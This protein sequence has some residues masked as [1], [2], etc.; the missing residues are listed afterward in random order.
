[1]ELVKNGTR[2]EAPG[3]LDGVRVL[4]IGNELG[5]YCGKMLA[6]LGA[7]VVRVEPPGGA[8]T[9]RFGPFLD[10]DETPEHSLYFWH[11]NF[12]KRGVTVDLDSEAG[13]DELAALVRQA[14]V[15]IDSTP[16][17]VLDTA[18]LD[19]RARAGLNPRLVDLRI[20]PFGD[21]GPYAEWL[22]TD[23]VHLALGGV[24]MNC[25]YDPGLHGHYDTPPVAPQMWHAFHITG[26]LAAMAVMGALLA[27][28]SSGRGQRL[29]TNVHQAVSQSTEIDVPNWIFLRT[30]HHRLTCRH[31]MP[32][33]T[34][35]V[36]AQ[37]K[38]GRY[39]LPYSTYLRGTTDPW[40][41]TVDLLAEHGLADDLGDGERW[42]PH[43]RT[44]R[45]G[46]QR[47]A[48]QVRRLLN[49]TLSSDE[50]WKEAQARALAWAPVRR[51]EENVGDPHWAARDTFCRLHDP[52][53][54]RTF[55]HVGAKWF[56]PDAP[57]RTG[58]RAPHV[59][60]H[61]GVVR[62][63]WEAAPPRVG[64][65]AVPPR[66]ITAPAHRDGKPF[67]LA[68]VRVVDLGWMLASAGAG[69]FLAALGAEVIKV[70]H[71]SRPDGMRFGRGTRPA[72]G[73]SAREAATE[74]LPSPPR[75]D[76]NQSGC[77]MTINSGKLSLGL[78]LKDPEGRQI[79]EDLIRNADV[80]SEGFSPGTLERMGFGYA[81][82]KELNPAIVYVQQSGF[83]STGTYGALR[84][85]G[86]TAQAVS[87]LSDMSGLPEPFPPAGIGY[88]F[89]D[90]HGAY[91]MAN[92]VLAALLRRDATGLPCH[93]DA[94]QAEVGLYLSGTAVLDHSAN[95]RSWHRYGN[96]SP[97][98]GA[99]P[100]GIYRTSG[101]DRWIALSVT[102]QP[103]WVA[104][105]DELGHPEWVDRYPDAASR[106]THHD[107][108]DVLIE[109]ATRELDGAGLMARLQSRGVAAGVCQTAQDRVD[110]DP[111]LAHL[112]WL[113]ELPQ[114][115]IGT[116]PVIDFPVRMSESAAHAGG[117]FDRSGPTYGEDTD[118]VLGTIL[119]RGEPDADGR[120]TAGQAL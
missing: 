31:A 29:D 110:G 6:G 62:A 100:S 57:W 39:V 73:R 53:L 38:D 52:E 94:S 51:P 42:P 20:T 15:L 16:R 26:E 8:P 21:D 22:G 24:V 109:A 30:P 41:G 14:D 3:Y 119:G 56:S 84:A 107:A 17:S 87:G 81:R 93:V 111:Q 85:Y 12:G 61:D 113:V 92:A 34:E 68:G 75:P 50:L 55:E 44:S 102:G 13:R 4:E 37:T 115:T 108:L 72:G 80:V 46:Q 19:R 43:A 69:R 88:S 33:A 67:P 114:S 118:H 95:G 60:E 120:S 32:T 45:V 11:Y 77:F 66:A 91:N 103:Q 64:P 71:T 117:R 1:M 35:S 106:R 65:P 105:A 40:D 10:D 27:R 49:R 9:R 112:E 89:L 23:L 2:S 59:G 82:L 98:T 48:D 70:E 101:P 90:W 18:G 5:E 79:L 99:A 28:Q 25:G 78:N 63:E 86:P 96:R 116:W 74:P 58:P 54:G 76:Q 97:A 104:L 47:M 36:L 83:G 7:D